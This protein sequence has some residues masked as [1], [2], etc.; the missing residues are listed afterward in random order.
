MLST[1]FLDS[2]PGEAARVLEGLSSV[3][4]AELLAEVGPGISGR[5]LGEMIAAAAG[6]VMAALPTDKAAALLTRLELPTATKILRTLEP[7]A[8]LAILHA[9]SS[10]IAEPLRRLLAYPEGTAGAV[11]D[12]RAVV[13]AADVS[14]R[15]TIDRLRHASG[16][17]LYYLYV[18]DRDDKLVGV[19]NI[20][21]L[22]LAPA[23]D[24]IGA[25][26]RKQV[27]R[28]LPEA[29]HATIIAHPKW[30]DVHAMP[31]ADAAGTFLGAV[32]YG[33]FRRLEAEADVEHRG[34]HPVALLAGISRMYWTVLL[35][36]VAL[37]GVALVGGTR[38]TRGAERQS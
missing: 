34:Q 19:V 16:N 28:L 6:D 1:A 21:E 36:V 5:V 33:T 35:Q 37:I 23:A 24:S 20:R 7:R 11:M 26:A 27:A 22:M 3:D 12:P 4:A 25:V 30:R 2:H 15:D 13:V 8:R 38:A 29:S 18:V 14:V 31:V 9:A 10:D 17:V 32:R